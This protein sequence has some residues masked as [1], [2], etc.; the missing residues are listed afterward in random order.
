MV[1]TTSAGKQQIAFQQLYLNAQSSR[2][3]S[4]Q[5]KMCGKVSPTVRCVAY[6]HFQYVIFCIIFMGY[7]RQSGWW[8]HVVMPTYSIP[9]MKEIFLRLCEPHLP[10][11]LRYWNVQLQGNRPLL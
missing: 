7:L 6:C 9:V 5:R 4:G 10:L 11:T 8:H 3:S 1:F 2:G